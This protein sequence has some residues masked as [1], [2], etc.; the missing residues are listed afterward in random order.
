M[1][2]VQKIFHKGKAIV[3]VDVSNCKPEE[4]IPLM[5]QAE[6]LIA[7]FPP[8]QALILTDVVGAQYNKSVA[9]RMKEFSKHNTPYVLASAAVGAAGV[10]LVLLQTLIFLTRREIKLFSTRAEALEW[11]VVQ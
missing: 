2:R 3:L 9:D 10:Q 6:K 1:D 7:S 4:T 8:K 5:E 11:L